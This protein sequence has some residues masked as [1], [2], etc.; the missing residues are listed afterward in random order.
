LHDAVDS[1][2]SNVIKI[3]HR[4]GFYRMHA[5][6]HQKLTQ[7]ALTIEIKCAHKSS[8]KACP[9]FGRK[10]SA[11]F[12]RSIPCTEAKIPS[13]FLQQMRLFLGCFGFA[14]LPIAFSPGVD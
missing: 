14:I 10:R 4:D 11:F 3:P 13:R 7:I 9:G 12:W 2:I 6:C 1:I 5:I 8:Q